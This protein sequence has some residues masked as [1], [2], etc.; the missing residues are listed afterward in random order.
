MDESLRN[1]L[2][3]KLTEKELKL[4]PSSYDVVGDILIFADFPEELVKKEKII[5]KK[6]LEQQ[7]H[8]KV[9]C[10]K[11]GKYSGKYRT[12]KLKI[13]AGEKRKETTHKENA[14]SMRLNV[15]SCYFSPRLSNERKRIADLVKKN[16]E[17][18]IMFA[19]VSPYS[20]VI[21][22]NSKPKIIYAIEINPKAHKYALE[23]VKLNKLEQKIKLSKGDVR[24]IVPKLNKRFDRVAMPLP[25][26]G[27]N[28]LDLALK[29]VKKKGM[30]HFYD[31]LHENNFHEAIE[32]VDLACRKTKKKYKILKLVK[33]GQFGPGIFRICIDFKV[34]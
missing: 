34:N 19:G 9:V 26:G 11:I 10:K 18:L 8:V 14:V 22:K 1:S 28:Y 5:A 24:K 3:K 16:E 17:I 30:V 29:A 6:L 20:L 25:K 23:N 12:P 7:K 31:F 27:E 15:E 4:L 13:I 33:C 2:K 32:K 21:A